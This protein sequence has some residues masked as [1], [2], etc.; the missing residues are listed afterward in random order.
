MHEEPVINKHRPNAYH[1]N[2]VGG[3][4]SRAPF[5]LKADTLL[6]QRDG[7]ARVTRPIAHARASLR[8]RIR[9]AM[10]T[11]LGGKNPRF[12]RLEKLFLFAPTPA[13]MVAKKHEACQL[14]RE[15]VEMGLQARGRFIELG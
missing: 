9:R 13:F 4:K 11:R 12:S 5:G 6:R 7:P 10:L 14:N 8:N 1:G 2:R 15:E 3:E